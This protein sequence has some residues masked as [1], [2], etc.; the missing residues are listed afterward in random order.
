MSTPSAPAAVGI[1]ISNWCKYRKV[2][3][4]VFLN[5][6]LRSGLRLHGFMLRSKSTSRWVSYTGR[7]WTN[8]QG[9]KQYIR[10]IMFRD[11]ETGGRFLNEIFMTVDAF[12]EGQIR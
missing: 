3:L 2:G 1:V 10:F 7:E 11:R 5:A 4:L 9:E 12:V 6:D 8:E